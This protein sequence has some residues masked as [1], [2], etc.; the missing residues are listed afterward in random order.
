MCHPAHPD[1]QFPYS[2]VDP[3]PVTTQT[4]YRLVMNGNAATRMSN[5]VL[6]SNTDIHLE[7]RSALNPFVDHISAEL[8]APAEGRAVLSLSDMYGRFVRREQVQVNMGLNNLNVYG[9]GGLPAG[10]Y[11]MQI[12]V[13]D[14]LISKK[15]VKVTK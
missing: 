1:S 14:Q 6:L 9:L 5:W 10:T 11:V 15:L 8:T 12:Q 2:F 3:N 13:G 7:V 4:Y